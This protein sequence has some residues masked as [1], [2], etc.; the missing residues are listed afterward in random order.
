MSRFYEADGENPAEN[1]YWPNL[2]RAC[3]SKRGQRVLREVVEALLALPQRRLIANAI[4]EPSGE[5]CAVGA[6]AQY[7]GVDLGEYR[8]GDQEDTIQIGESIGMG[9]MIPWHLGFMND[10]QLPG[11]E[12]WELERA[13][14]NGNPFVWSEQKQCYEYLYR[15]AAY[16]EVWDETSGRIR[17]VR[18]RESIGEWLQARCAT[19]E[20]RWDAIYRWACSQIEWNLPVPVNA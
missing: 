16:V 6:V 1:L 8:E 3:R 7:K 5:V 2:R 10:T 15:T 9:R 19:P 12:P 4:K 20:Q 11:L 13:K 18:E 17:L 14:R